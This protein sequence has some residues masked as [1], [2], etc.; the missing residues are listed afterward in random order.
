MKR[1]A[2]EFNSQQYGARLAAFEQ[3]NAMTSQAFADKFSKGE[4]GDDERWFEWE[5]VLDGYR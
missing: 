5:F 2:L 1:N 3:Q 4:L